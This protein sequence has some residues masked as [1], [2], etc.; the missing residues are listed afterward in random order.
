[1]FEL[2][3]FALPAAIIGAVGVTLAGGGALPRHAEVGF[4]LCVAAAACAQGAWSNG[5][6]TEQEELGAAA[7][8]HTELSLGA[9]G[10]GGTDHRLWDADVNGGRGEGSAL[11]DVAYR[12]VVVRETGTRTDVSNARAMGTLVVCAAR[13]TRRSRTQWPSTTQAQ[14]AILD[15]EAAELTL[16]A[17]GVAAAGLQLFLFVGHV[18]IRKI[19]VFFELDVFDEVRVGLCLLGPIDVFEL[20]QV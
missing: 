1:M 11:T 19:I 9:V 8:H 12:A 20:F 13:L 3:L 17:V 6:A 15:D 4:A 5:L 10:V 18:E 14:L 2:Q 7:V 16:F